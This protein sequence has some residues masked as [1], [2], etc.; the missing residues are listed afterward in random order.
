VQRTKV[1]VYALGGFFIGLSGVLEFG[2]LNMGQPT[3]AQTYELYV[4]AACVIG[5]TSLTGGVGTIFGT[6][7][8]ALIIGTLNVG[9][10]QAGWEKRH[11]EIAIGVIIIVAVALDQLRNWKSRT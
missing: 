9:T 11:Q 2:K 10:Q 4:I 3:G 1:I 7:I 5:G 6:V 8:G